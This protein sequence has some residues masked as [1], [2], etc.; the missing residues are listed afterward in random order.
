MKVVIWSHFISPRLEYF[1][2]WLEDRWALDVI[3]NEEIPSQEGII[4]HYGNNHTGACAISIPE[5]GLLS[6]NGINPVDIKAD[7]TGAHCKLFYDSDGQLDLDFD[8]FSMTFY[9]LSRYEEYQEVE[10]DEHGRWISAQ[11]A[12]VRHGFIQ[13]PLIDLWLIYIEGIIESKTPHRFNRSKSIRY[14]PTIDVDIPYAYKRKEWRNLAGLMRDTAL[15]ER[16]KINARIAYMRTHIDPYDTYGYLQEQLQHFG[17]AIFFFLCNYQKPYDENH[18]IGKVEFEQLVGRLA[19]SHHIGIH[20]SYFSDSNVSAIASEKKVL[21][22]ITDQ[23]I[24][25]SRQHY[26]KMSIPQ[27]YRALIA[28]SITNDHSMVYADQLGFRASTCHPFQWYDLSQERT[29]GLTI[30]SPSLM[31]VTCKKY[32]KLDPDETK[33]VIDELKKTISAVNGT[34]EFIWHNSSFSAAHGWDGWQKVFEY[35]LKA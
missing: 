18:L 15:G 9:L 6:Q 23:I 34:F 26:L 10:T 1:A 3:F 28:A 4:I 11:S 25:A 19:Q 12:A 21:E 33:I 20:P 24:T 5:S 13:A 16:T 31:D 7:T 8:F 35:L 17:D 30:H 14:V 32:L 2:Q 27:T 22:T 29:T